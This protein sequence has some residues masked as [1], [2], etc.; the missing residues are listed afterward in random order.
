VE[1]DP[2]KLVTKRAG[3]YDE[4]KIVRESTPLILQ[5]SRINPAFFA[6]SEEYFYVPCPHCGE[7][8]QLEWGGRT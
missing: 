6:G 2:T 8:Q 1:G 5:H 7:H 4:P 3:A